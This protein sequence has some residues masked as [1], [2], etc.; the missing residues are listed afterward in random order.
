MVPPDA[1]TAVA[2]ATKPSPI[3][4]A[5]QSSM[6]RNSSPRAARAGDSVADCPTIS[7]IAASD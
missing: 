7:E 1:N 5:H 3:Q 2:S 6:R 4:I